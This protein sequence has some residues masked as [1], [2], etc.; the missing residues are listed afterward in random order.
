MQKYGT[1]HETYHDDTVKFI[2]LQCLIYKYVNP[3]LLIKVRIPCL[4]P[5]GINQ[6]WFGERGPVSTGWQTNWRI[7]ISSPEILGCFIEIPPKSWA[8]SSSISTYHCNFSESTKFDKSILF[9]NMF[10]GKP[11]LPLVTWPLHPG[12]FSV[13]F[14][15]L[16]R[17]HRLEILQVLLVRLPSWWRS[18][19]GDGRYGPH[20][21]G[22]FSVDDCPFPMIFW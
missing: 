11:N 20:P 1:K 16:W 5:S 17:L 7:K 6:S 3:R 12:W 4:T 10:W 18:C 14:P 13:D 21:Q 19:L 22:T 8:F 15:S 9:P 2:K